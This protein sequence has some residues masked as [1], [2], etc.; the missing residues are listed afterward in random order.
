MRYGEIRKPEDVYHVLRA[1]RALL[2]AKG[3]GYSPSRWISP[4]PAARRLRVLGA[5]PR[6][7]FWGAIATDAAKSPGALR[8][9][10]TCAPRGLSAQ[11]IRALQSML[12]ASFSTP[13]SGDT[14]AA[15][16][17]LAYGNRQE[18]PMTHTPPPPAARPQWDEERYRSFIRSLKP[19]TPDM[20]DKLTRMVAVTRAYEAAHAD[21]LRTGDPS[22]LKAVL[23]AMAKAR[24]E[25][26]IAAGADP[27]SPDIFPPVPVTPFN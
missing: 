17:G 12:V 21:Y 2:L 4:E 15:V 20:R 16:D 1:L 13:A 24:R 14:G 9:P 11:N 10:A 23:P 22:L 25:A 3:G 27:D 5:M 8:A 6:A 19:F 26:L 7:A 18:L